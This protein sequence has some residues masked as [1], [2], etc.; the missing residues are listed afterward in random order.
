[1][2]SSHEK[3]E[4]AVDCVRSGA[5]NYVVKNES[6]FL[7]LTHHINLILYN[8][9]LREKGRRYLAWNIGFATAFLIIVFAMIVYGYHH[10]AY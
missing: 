2:L 8:A 1:M 10:A 5:Y 4:I 7:L 3:L 6:A 9:D